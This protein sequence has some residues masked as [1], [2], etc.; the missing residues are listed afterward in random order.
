V[1]TGVAPIKLGFLLDHGTVGRDPDPPAAQP[2]ELVFREGQGS[3][4]IDRP[5]QVIYRGVEGLPEGKSR[6]SLTPSVN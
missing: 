6:R 1:A 3:G 5:V 2:M 4:L